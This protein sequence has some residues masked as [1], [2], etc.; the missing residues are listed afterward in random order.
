MSLRTAY[1]QVAGVP[2]SFDIA[3][4][5]PLYSIKVV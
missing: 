5:Q 3:L 2:P 1:K 4:E